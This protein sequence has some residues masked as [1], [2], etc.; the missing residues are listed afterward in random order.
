MIAGDRGKRGAF[1]IVSAIALVM[2]MT[3]I[4]A[5]QE[6]QPAPHLWSDYAAFR[7][8]PES[9]DAYVEF[10]FEMKRV[11][12]AF[13][14][15]DGTLRADVYTWIL[16]TDTTGAPVDSAGGAFVS[17]VADSTELADSTF[18]LFFAR[19][20]ILP[21]G[22]Y[23]A[24]AVVAD[25]VSK[26]TNEV[27]YPVTVPDFSSNALN[28]SNIELGYNIFDKSGDTLAARNDVLVK[29]M[30]KV[31][32]DCRGLVGPSRPRLLFY[33]EVY[34]LNFDPAQNNSYTMELSIL[35]KA[36]EV[37]YAE[38]Q[39]TLT[40][41]G[42][43]AV[44]ATGINVGELDAGLYTLKLSVTDPASG[45][46]VSAEK[47]FEKVAPQVPALTPEE[48][49]RIRDIIAYIAHPDELATFDRLNAVGKR[50]F[51]DKFWR[52]RDPTPGTPE[53]E[54][55]IEHLRRMNYANERFS[56]SFSD[57]T[58]GWRTDMGRIYIL[59]GP[60]DHVERYP[61]TLDRPA[62]EMWF[63]DQLPNQGEAYFLFIDE[64]GYGEYNLVH[65][66]AR[67]ERRDP[68]WERQI[69]D[70]AFERTQ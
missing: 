51:W 17:V 66:T 11:D 48:A 49:E 12:F 61:Y 67:G 31:Y 42:H 8:E 63:Y 27:R 20:L 14:D 58:D 54:A 5:S 68:Y 2:L 13:R 60:P 21:P 56:V 34:N 29:N 44:L 57:R 26:A 33:S 47:A 6:E 40:K 45:Q 18:I 35:D 65:S 25:L 16:V 15:V 69:R 36:G 64:A 7:L 24:Q 55:K 39:Q 62:G 23:R 50:N 22:D 46:T 37:A 1:T 70:G 43:D 53:N 3:V 9:P 59:H 32:P 30:Q 19:Y 28:I 10:Y 4:G 41:P 52:D 38:G